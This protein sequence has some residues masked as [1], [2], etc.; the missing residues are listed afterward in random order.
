VPPIPMLLTRLP[1]QALTVEAQVT[2]LLFNLDAYQGSAEPSMKTARLSFIV[3]FATLCQ[4]S[5]SAAHADRLLPLEQNFNLSA[6]VF[7]VDTNTRIR[8]D[9]E[10]VDLGTDI[11]L[12]DTFGFEDQSR[13]R[14]DGYW[15]FADRHKVRFMYFGSRLE[16]SR[17]IA[18]EIEFNDQIFPLNATVSAEFKTE[19][20][21][22]AYEYSFL[23]RDSFEL[24]GT[25]GLHNLRVTATLNTVASSNIGAGGIDRSAEAK[26]DGPLP[27]VGLRA[28]WAFSDHWFLD[29]QVQYFGLKFDEYDGS[30]QDLKLTFVWQPTKYFGL[31]VGYNDFSTR[32][33]VD[34]DNFNGRLRL[35]YGGPLAFLSVGF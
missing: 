33:D 14:I 30:L 16:E 10:T 11:D 1:G 32:L 4:L 29:A 35:G 21:E 27:L 22:L 25:I 13:L 34:G 9:G 23:R 24:A 19:I 31:G 5:H 15:R 6:G 12:D 18:E 2:A 26:G 3:A 7:V 8:V 20:V 17:T 28:L